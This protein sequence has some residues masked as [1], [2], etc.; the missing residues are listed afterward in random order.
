M[1][2]INLPKAIPGIRGLLVAFPE[3]GDPLSA[4]TQQLL[5]GQSTLTPAERELI[6]ACVSQA[7]DCRFCTWSHAAAA[8]QF[9]SGNQVEMVNKVVFEQD[10]SPLSDKMTALV[11]IALTVRKGGQFV[12][13]NLIDKAR[14]A[15][16]DEKAIHDTVLIAAA[17]C[18]FNRYVDGLAALT[19]QETTVYDEI[20]KRLE[21][22]DMNLPVEIIF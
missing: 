15:G 18:M 8:K 11:E 13:Q 14:T 2:Y 4:F 17:F 9:F 16:A 7:N 12:T 6:A 21:P 19:P 3:T 10:T 20:G 22:M 1:S 5:R